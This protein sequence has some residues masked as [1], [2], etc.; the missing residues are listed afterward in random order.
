MEDLP[1]ITDRLKE[2][3]WSK[4][5]TSGNHPRGCWEWQGN[6]DKWGRGRF[7][8]GKEKYLRT[9][10]VA[11]LLANGRLADKCVCH[12]CDNPPCC[13]PEHLWDGTHVDNMADMIQKNR[14]PCG[15]MTPIAKL[16][17]AD[18]V[19]I[20]NHYVFGVVGYKT[21]AKKYNVNWTQIRDIIKGKRWKHVKIES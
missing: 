9:H 7:Y 3:F 10:Q 5:D 11:F 2:R 19:E 18:V 8:L 20:N 16:T 21:L 4:V 1:P 6:R 13:N 17:E 14:K 12:T 15:S